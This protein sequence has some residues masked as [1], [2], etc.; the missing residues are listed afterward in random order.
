[1]NCEGNKRRARTAGVRRGTD[2]A[3]T[4]R[5]FVSNFIELGA[6][7]KTFLAT[8]LGMGILLATGAAYAASGHIVI[9][10]QSAE[11]GVWVSLLFAV[12]VSGL[13]MWVRSQMAS[14]RLED[15]EG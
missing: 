5:R 4:P 2:F 7:M 14:E 3:S 15:P 8:A 9:G 1:M 10:E 13:V 11:T 12:V 6:L